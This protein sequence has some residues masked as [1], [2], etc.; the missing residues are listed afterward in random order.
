MINNVHLRKKEIGMMQAIGMTDRQLTQLLMREGV[1]Y[2]A[3]ALILSICG[4]SLLGYPI[5]LW[6]R[7]NGMFSI[8]RYHYPFTSAAILILLLLAIQIL[9]AWLL[10]RSVKKESLIERVRF[11]E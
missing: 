5:F 10:G 3:G 11:S 7:E 6:A 8:S 1:F 2:I 4:G 9:L